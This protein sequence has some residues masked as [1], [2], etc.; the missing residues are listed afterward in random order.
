MIV[1]I[2]PLRAGTAGRTMHK[3]PPRGSRK[4]AVMRQR[5]DLELSDLERPVVELTA[6]EAEPIRGGSLLDDVLGLDP[7]ILHLAARLGADAP[8]DLV[9]VSLGARNST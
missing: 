5:L 2:R 8:L 1:I 3:V 6:E 4:N 7:A 9:G